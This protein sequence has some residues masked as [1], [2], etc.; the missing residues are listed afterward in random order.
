MTKDM[1]KKIVTTLLSVVGIFAVL[2]MLMGEVYKEGQSRPPIKYSEISDNTVRF[3]RGLVRLGGHMMG[4]NFVQNGPYDWENSKDLGQKSD[5]GWSS[6]ED[7]FFIVYYK[8]DKEA[9]WQGYAQSILRAAN[10]NIM[11]L[12]RL[13]GKY[14]FPNDQNGRKL[15]IYLASN[16]DEYFET[17]T[18][19]LERP[20]QSDISRSIGITVSFLG[21]A[22]CKAS[23]VLHPICFQEPPR[24]PNGYICVLMHEMNHYVFLSSLDLSK[25]IGFCNWQIEGLADYCACDFVD[26]KRQ[27]QDSFRIQFIKDSCM[28]LTDFPDNIA[29][30]EYWAG[31]SYY[32]YLEKKNGKEFVRKFI[33]ATYQHKTETLF[34]RMDLDPENEHEEWVKSL[35]TEANADLKGND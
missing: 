3:L 1:N 20:S 14:Y 11:P 12:T 33:Q 34:S 15:P 18:K 17:I 31:E 8:K 35:R 24:S 28:L 23:I 25:N 30:S 4:V 16:V 26:Y 5:E 29:D 6:E 13:M 19:L 2:A 27:I 21:G 9:V 7:E 10:E 22:G 32:R